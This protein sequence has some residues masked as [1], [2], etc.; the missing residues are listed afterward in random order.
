[1]VSDDFEG[2]DSLEIVVLFSVIHQSG[3]SPWQRSAHHVPFCNSHD[4]LQSRR[5]VKHPLK[6]REP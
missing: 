1:M 3:Q 2:C 4:F 6:P 5:S